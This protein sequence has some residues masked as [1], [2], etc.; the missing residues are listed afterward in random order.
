MVPLIVRLREFG[1]P[2]KRVSAFLAAS[3]AFGGAETGR[4]SGLLACATCRRETAEVITMTVAQ[5][6]IVALAI[7]IIAGAIATV[8]TCILACQKRTELIVEADFW[9][10]AYAAAIKD[11]KKRKEGT[12]HGADSQHL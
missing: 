5:L 8:S 11:S 10:K 3:T 6:I 12:D 9:R 4:V 2:K 1:T 7:S